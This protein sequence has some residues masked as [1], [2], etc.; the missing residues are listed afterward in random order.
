MKKKLSYL[1]I[2]V[3]LAFF[4][5]TLGRTLS[6][7]AYN[8]LKMPVPTSSID[9][10]APKDPKTLKLVTYNVLVLLTHIEERAQPLFK[11]LED[12]D[13]DIIALQEV[14]GWFT[15]MLAKSPMAKKYAQVSLV[16]E[17]CGGQ[18]ILTKYPV[19][20]ARCV[21]LPGKQ[22]RTVLFAT[23]DVGGRDLTVATTHMTSALE[24]GA[25][26]IEELKVIF[27]EL[28]G[29][30][31][32]LVMGDLN[33]G[34][35]VPEGN[36]IPA[37]F[38][39]FWLTLRPGEPGFTWDNEKSDMAGLSP[40]RF[41]GEPSRRLDWILL[42]SDTW[43]PQSVEIIGNEP[44]IPGRKDIFPSDHFGVAGVMVRE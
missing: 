2:A 13:A 20:K 17:W 37:T 6:F 40:E 14:G 41:T 24:A 23:L 21:P 8:H 30:G 42:R 31:D 32:A 19:K 18:F 27:N 1:L 26:R 15:D 12:S 43:K 16:T 3:V 38:I 44:V 25:H 5:F 33:F 39:D 4:V 11:I 22:W 35:G 10:D 7:V 29:V 36:A 34:D 9:I 28:D